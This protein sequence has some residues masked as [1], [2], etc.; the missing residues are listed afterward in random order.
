M[1]EHDLKGPEEVARFHSKVCTPLQLFTNYQFKHLP[2]VRAANERTNSVYCLWDDE[3]R[4]TVH[5]GPWLRTCVPA[6]HTRLMQRC[7]R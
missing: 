3:V 5:A 2:V 6:L 7:A 1:A 4:A